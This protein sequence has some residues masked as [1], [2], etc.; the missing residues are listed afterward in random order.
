M[1]WGGPTSPP[2]VF[3]GGRLREV[4]QQP[5]GSTCT[6]SRSKAAEALP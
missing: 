3:P 1:G 6:L 2:D 4:E 5:W